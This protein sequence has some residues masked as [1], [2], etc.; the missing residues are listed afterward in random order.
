MTS[1]ES[2]FNN[3]DEGLVI[4]SPSGD[5]VYF[6]DGAFQIFQK[7]GVTLNES[8]NIFQALPHETAQRLREKITE[9]MTKKE[10][11]RSGGDQ[12]A[13][14]GT[15]LYLDEIFV[16]T[17]DDDTITHVNLLL[18]DNTEA[19]IYEKKI[20]GMA[21]ELR[22]LIDQANAVIIGTDTRGYIT[23]WNNHTSVLTS[24]T[25]NEA[26]TQKFTTLLMNERDQ[27]M[28]DDCVK[29][30]LQG[31]SLINIE[32]PI[33]SKE[34]QQ[35]IFL[36]SATARLNLKNDIT[37]VVFVGQDISLRLKIERE[38]K[39]AHDRLMFHLEN[40][41]LG[42]IEWDD[43]LKPKSWTQTVE[44]IFGWKLKEFLENNFTALNTI[45]EED[46]PAT[47]KQA[48]ELLSGKLDRNHLQ[49]RNM[50]KDGRVIWC[51]WFN[52][53]LKDENGKVITIM[54][55][56]QDITERKLNE[57]NLQEALLELEAYKESLEIKVKERTE[58]LMEA[59]K[60]EKDVVEMK[61][62]FVSI[63]SHEFRT[64]LSS[65]QYAANFLRKSKSGINDGDLKEKLRDIEKQT[66]HMM[67][68]LDDVLTY[69]KS[70]AGKIQLKI[71]AIELKKFLTKII[72]DVSHAT[73]DTHTI[74]LRLAEAKL[75]IETDEKLLR[76]I[77][78]NLLSNA[79][80]YSPGKKK[81]FLRVDST[82]YLIKFI[83]IDEGVGIPNEEHDKVFDAFVRGKLTENIQGTGLGLS[84]V[85][86]SVEL[87]KGNIKL[88]SQVNKG[89]TI[90]VTI[91]KSILL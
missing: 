67:Y 20:T 85:K 19:R 15:P 90:T 78:I 71:T 25:K 18:R 87:M 1:L 11:V 35:M 2:I 75:K 62:R 54:S 42:F 74:E 91:P 43:Q 26:L 22:N 30:T 23:D 80:K 39:F 40:S 50:T 84:I 4:L 41:P 13:V 29:R 28:F 70:E 82:K 59:L 79:I 51:E 8:D 7:I 76:N 21:T 10:T 12:T 55:L 3:I 48:N 49:N 5:Q 63:A 60:K 53:V 57:L 89:T 31:E 86:K 6:N 58:E 72:E 45:Y 52:S 44:E 47:I 27:P 65:I 83:I 77:L 69:G 14:D 16:P 81:V 33:V 38:F 88:D 24:Y 61:S 68:L 36:L 46:A 32:V 56:V 66:K 34:G 9:V 64:P 73:K 17:F 37:G